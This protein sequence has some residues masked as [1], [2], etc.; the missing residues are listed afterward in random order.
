MEANVG[1][2]T[3]VPTNDPRL[4][5]PVRPQCNHWNGH[6]ARCSRPATHWIV[7]PDGELNPGGWI[8]EPCGTAIIDEYREKIGQ[9]WAL[10]PLRIVESGVQS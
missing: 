10:A 8:C 1:S 9:E 7:A 5:W 3:Q 4:T 2:P 6:S